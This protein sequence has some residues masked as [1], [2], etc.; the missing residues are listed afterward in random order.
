MKIAVFSTK[1]YDRQFLDEENKHHNHEIAYFEGRLR[2]A[3]APLANGY[4]AVCV[5]VND[6]LDKP[7]LEILKQGGTTVIALRCAGFNNVDL[8]TA[9]RLGMTVVRVPAYSPYAVAEHTVALLLAMNRKIHRAHNR[10]HDG[11]FAL[12][13]LLGFDLH[14]KTV[15]VIGTGKIGE[16]FTRIMKGFGCTIHAYDVTPNPE[17]EAAGVTYVDLPTLFETSDIISLH[18]PLNPNTHHLIDAAAIDTMKEGVM[19]INTS[20]GGLIDAVALI[21]GLKSGKVGNVGL[22]VYEEESDLFFEDLS[23]KVI[24]D[25]VFARLLSFPNV[26]ITGHQAFFTSNALQNIAET[27]LGNISQLESGENCPNQVL[28]DVIQS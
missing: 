4:D 15:G 18:C 26:I 11:N 1:A 20:R 6:M 3:S 13:G 28:P 23:G 8:V 9:D 14:G 24:Q 19:I 16:V 27:T 17:C 21:G 5:F 25:D 7:T 22:D 12:D 2:E 10:V